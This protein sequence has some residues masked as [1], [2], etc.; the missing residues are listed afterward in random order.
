MGAPENL[1]L[2]K[3]RWSIAAHG[4]LKNSTNGVSAHGNLRN[5]VFGVS[6]QGV[7]RKTSFSIR[8]SGVSLR[9]GTSKTPLTEFLRSC[10]G[11]SETPFLEFLR[12]GY[13]RKLRYL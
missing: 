8:H 2:N 6:A 7:R 13:V 9:M 5:S 10:R 12:R 1:V 4:N 3:T 11:T